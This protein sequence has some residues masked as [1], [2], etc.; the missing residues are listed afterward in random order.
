MKVPDW[1]HQNPELQNVTFINGDDGSKIAVTMEYL[2]TIQFQ[3]A[4]SANYGMQ[5]GMN[6]ILLLIMLLITPR[7]KLKL[8]ICLVNI[9]AIVF[10]MIRELSIITAQGKTRFFRTYAQMTYGA[11][12]TDMRDFDT[13]SQACL[14]LTEICALLAAYMVELLLFLQARVILSTLSRRYWIPTMV[15]L[16]A[17]SLACLG[18]RTMWT[19]DNIDDLIHITVSQFSLP[20]FSEKM[21]KV[22]GGLIVESIAAYSI[23]FTSRILVLLYRRH[24]MGVQ[25]AKPLQVLIFI[26]LESMIVPGKSRNHQLG[27]LS[28][29]SA[30]VILVACQWAHNQPWTDPQTWMFASVAILMPFGS[31]W[32]S[33]LNYRKEVGVQ[34]FPDGSLGVVKDQKSWDA[35]NSFSRS[36]STS[37]K[38]FANG[39]VQRPR[40]S[41]HISSPPRSGTAASHE[42]AQL[43]SDIEKGEGSSTGSGITVT[44]DISVTSFRDDH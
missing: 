42:L 44:H 15:F 18:M 32:S 13:L 33:Q 41:V 4:S 40:Y 12:D 34:N 24:K 5:F 16:G 38:V 1:L 2:D 31:I 20:K 25:R 43:G 35:S 22:T 30:I 29:V 3:N 27:S 19:V 8:P 14:Y 36:L 10:G 23:V 26:S 17:G 28:N 37:S 11:G 39:N 6:F 21:K 9:A 7:E